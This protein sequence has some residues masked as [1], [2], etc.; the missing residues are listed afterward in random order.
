MIPALNM[1]DDKLIKPAPQD[2]RT[3]RS[4][5]VAFASSKI[6]AERLVGNLKMG[7]NFPPQGIDWGVELMVGAEHSKKLG[8][9]VAKTFYRQKLFIGKGKKVFSR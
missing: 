3:V 9:E 4:Q 5:F 8:A 1:I 6:K 2:V 7:T